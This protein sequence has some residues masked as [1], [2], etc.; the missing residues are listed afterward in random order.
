MHI[1]VQPVSVPESAHLEYLFQDSL[2]RG[3][4]PA[5]PSNWCSSSKSAGGSWNSNTQRRR[6]LRDKRILPGTE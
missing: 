5:W 2:P 3:A 4:F 1:I 6:Q